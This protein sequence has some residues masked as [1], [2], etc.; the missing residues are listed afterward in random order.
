MPDLTADHLAKL[1]A[2][3]FG[4]FGLLLP[5]LIG[6]AFVA[7]GLGALAF[8]DL[9]SSRQRVLGGLVLSAAVF[10]GGLQLLLHAGVLYAHILFSLFA[11]LIAGVALARRGLPR[12]SISVRSWLRAARREYSALLVGAVCAFAIGIAGLAAYLLPI[13]QWD[14]LGYHLPFVNF[15]LQG[16]GLAELPPDIPYLSTYPRNVALLF[17]G[18]RTLLPDDRL[19]D[20]GQLPF[21][22]VGA[23][24]TAGIARELGARR[25]DAFVAGAL[26]LV[27]PAVFLQLPT[28]YVDVGAAAYL[29][30]ASFFVLVPPTRASLLCAGLAL[31]LFLGT[32]PNTPPAVVL[33]AAFLGW[34]A[35]RAGQFAYGMLALLLTAALGLEAYVTEF[36]RHGN[37]VWPAIVDLG[38]LHLPGTI[39]VKELLSSGAG[40]P[41]VYGPLPWRVLVS[42][43]SLDAVPA[44]DMRVGG[45][46]P[47][48]WLA[49]PLG[50]ICVVRRRL[51]VLAGLFALALVTPDPAVVRY[52][53]AFP[54]LVFAAAAAAL[55]GLPERARRLAHLLCA[56]ASAWAL[57]R[58][59]PALTGEGP[60]LLAYLSM[61]W[62]ERSV[63]V[64][65]DGPPR[66]FVAAQR[67]LAPG[68]VAVYD[69]A[70]NFPY[71][72]W[73]S[74]LEN[75][76][77][78][79]P[80]AAGPVAIEQL[81][82][83]SQ[84][85]LV[86]A[87]T[88]LP[89]A[90]VVASQPERFAPLFQCRERC[91]AYLRR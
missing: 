19:L 46:G 90:S 35:Q 89:A 15:V 68:E 85:R 42:W 31:G 17:A 12:S 81:L 75:R 6:A 88:D 59:V 16:G 77:I 18:L 41:K 45:L 29:L 24:A 71:L 27:L 22:L 74:D 28:N 54:A 72:M 20:I 86:L 49:V 57:T 48:F 82:A 30:L 65:G 73:R 43:L 58:A 4:P 53:L 66:E 60:P 69:R 25:A 87:G 39:S 8:R 34:R 5:G 83:T 2:P 56:L 1:V 67:R 55:A 51:G 9:L 79:I 84:A 37:P 23:A 91:R 52:V 7:E 64:G 40:T 38:P 50:M 70:L 32:K 78:R 63:A 13:W 14:A 76:V 62:P 61:S 36:I 26:W 21:G 3:V 80:D 11:A 47:A 44:F 10:T 33:F